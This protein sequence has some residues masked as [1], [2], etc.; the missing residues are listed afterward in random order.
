MDG[1][2]FAAK[3]GMEGFLA[4]LGN[5][6]RNRHAPEACALTKGKLV[7]FRNTLQKAHTLEAPAA[8]EGRRAN[9]GHALR[10]GYAGQPIALLEGPGPDGP[11]IPR[12]DHMAVL[13][14][15]IQQNVI[16]CRKLSQPLPPRRP[17]EAVARKVR[18]LLR[19]LYGFQ[20]RAVPKRPAPDLLHTLRDIHAPKSRAVLEC[21]IPDTLHSLRNADALQPRAARERVVSNLPD[22]LQKGH[23]GQRPAV[24]ERVVSDGRDALRDDRMVVTSL[25]LRQNAVLN[26]K[27]PYL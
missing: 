8:S 16:H 7:N 19:K 5:A 10:D 25:V 3:E 11:D 26:N 15:V 6:L 12:N 2:G 9:P 27:N 23:A 20:I 18:E 22:A 21:L 24:P 14:Y 1:D 17:L 4:N 13:S